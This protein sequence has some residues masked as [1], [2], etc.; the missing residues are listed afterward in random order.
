MHSLSDES[1]LWKRACNSIK[2]TFGRVFLSF[3]HLHKMFLLLHSNASIFLSMP[4][5]SPYLLFSCTIILYEYKCI[6][7]LLG[8]TKWVLFYF[9][10]LFWTL[11]WTNQMIFVFCHMSPS[12]DIFE[13]RWKGMTFSMLKS[14]VESKVNFP[15]WARNLAD[16]NLRA[17]FWL[18]PKMFIILS[19]N[20]K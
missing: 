2:S 8:N 1:E 10:S 3:F 11:F 19:I 20:Y 15:H 7:W 6:Y 12:S 9:F 16:L 5:N 4:Q 13:V 18:N 17:E 14:K